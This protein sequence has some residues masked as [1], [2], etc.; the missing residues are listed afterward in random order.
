MERDDRFLFFNI[1]IEFHDQ[2]ISS[3]KLYI[4]IPNR[5]KCTR[6]PRSWN[7]QYNFKGLIAA[8]AAGAVF[9]KIY[10]Y[11]LLTLLGIKK[12]SDIDGKKD[13]DNKNN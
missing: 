8:L 6:L 11:K 9:V 5:F 7:W 13:L 4:F 2:K 3:N 10:W 1:V 12:K